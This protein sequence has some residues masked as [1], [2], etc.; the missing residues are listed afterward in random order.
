VKLRTRFDPNWILV[1]L[2]TV[3]AVA[4]LTYPGFFEAG[5]GFLPAFNVAHLLEAPD[6]AG[7]A[8]M[9]RGEGALSYVLVWPVYRLGGSGIVA[10]KWGYGLAFLLGALGTYAWTR[11]RLGAKGGVLSAT[12]YTYLPWHLSTVYVRGA[13]AEAW[14]WALWPWILWAVD[15]LAGQNLRSM[16]GAVAV[17]LALAAATLWVQPGLATLALPLLIAYG[18]IVSTRRS[19]HWLALVETAGLLALFLLFAIG[20]TAET[21]VPFGEQFL[22]PF[23]LLSAAWDRG[24]SYQLGV[25]TVGLS[26][27][28]VALYVGKRDRPQGGSDTSSSPETAPPLAFWF[29]LCSLLVLVFLCLPI[30]AWFWQVTGFEQLLT[31]PWQVLAL[32]GMPLAFL[33]GSVI[34][35]DRRLSELPALAG[36]VALVVLAS[37]PYLAPRYTQVDPGPEPVAL[38]QPVE[39]GTPQI[40]LLDARVGQPVELGGTQSLTATLTWQAVEPVAQDYTAFVHVLAADGAKIAQRDTWPCD[41]ECPTGSWQ[42][43]EVIVD[44]YQLNWGQDAA[45]PSTQPTQ[46]A[47]GLYLVESG[48]RAL[49][50]GREDRTVFLDVP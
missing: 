11:R 42:P 46:L 34:R 47:V 20:T 10:V 2:L 37:Y 17:S 4:P 36:V 23:Q 44:H 50:A 1:L 3:F 6:W 39:A 43:G 28:A 5:S 21:Q 18:I 15:H 13:Y 19:W 33:A 26:I 22:H 40:L 41:G 29:W 31:Y 35:L 25:A 9:V 16:V 24:Q 12:V 14:L 7:I 48:D 49:V 27:V 32:S 30:S 45:V 8:G 38:F